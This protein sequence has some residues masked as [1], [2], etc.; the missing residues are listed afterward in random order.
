MKT[1]ADRT[2]I[3][4]LNTVV[5]ENMSVPPVQL[6]Q[7][8]GKAKTPFRGKTCTKESLRRVIWTGRNVKTVFVVR[9]EGQTAVARLNHG[10]INQK[11]ARYEPVNSPH[12]TVGNRFPRHFS[13]PQL[14]GAERAVLGHFG[15]K[16]LGL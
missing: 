11:V 13:A 5:D 2:I 12:Q 14:R 8:L 1:K 10:N 6:A 4:A 9:F 3:P 15:T 16:F 7:E